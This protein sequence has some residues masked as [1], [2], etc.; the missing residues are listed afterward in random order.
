MQASRIRAALAALAALV[1]VSFA[2]VRADEITTLSVRSGHSIVV[3]APGL[4]RVAVGDGRIAGVIPIGRQE[5]IVNGKTAGQTTLFIWRGGRRYNYE[6]SVTEQSVDD[7]AA[8]LRSTVNDPNVQIISFDRSIVARGF[9]QTPEQKAQLDDV[10]GRFEADA[11]A[12]KYTV[13]DAVTVNQPLGRLQ[14]ELAAVPGAGAVQV[15]RDG[16][17]DLIVT[18]RVRDRFIAEN[19]LDRVRAAGG[20]YLSP[21][22]KVIDRLATDTNSQ[23]D[24]KVYIL[25]VDRT[26]LDQLGVR[27][28]SGVPDP[29]HPGQYIL[30]DPNFPLQESATQNFSGKPNSGPGI[31]GRALN[32]GAFYRTTILAPTVDLIM[33]SGHARMLSSPDL[34][35]L[36]G[37]QATFLVG[38]QI[39]IPFASGP[40]QIAIV[41][42]DFGVKLDIVPLLLGNGSVETKISPEV[43][44]LDFQD[45]IET[46]G[47]IVPALKTSRLSTDVVTTAGQSIIMGGLLRR[48]EQ[49]NIDKI[50][51]LGDLPILGKLFRSTRYQSQQ[52][53]VIFVMTPTV[54]TQ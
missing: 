34:V 29:N 46:S 50:P 48:V 21:D 7:I 54:L 37:R 8:M 1:L 6:V 22:G 32:V 20:A 40:G 26:A 44:D 15:D 5:V 35:T 30:S 27:L 14:N 38:G 47:F 49:R 9:V 4:A 28:Q 19:V 2:P 3:P 45:G 36:P 12:N 52:T 53:D 25:E 43:S 33:R 51:L 41:Y 42:K 31:A 13:V 11:K 23:V 18:G 39:P 17:G 24:I 10:L 16:K